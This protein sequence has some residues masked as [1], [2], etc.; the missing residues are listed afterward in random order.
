MPKWQIIRVPSLADS[1]KQ[2][3][4][5]LGITNLLLST[6]FLISLLQMEI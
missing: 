2:I 5:S 4:K 6:L 3:Q 1:P